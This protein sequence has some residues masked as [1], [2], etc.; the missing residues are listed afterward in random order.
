[1]N[2]KSP[3]R[4]HARPEGA[5]DLL[6]LYLFNMALSRYVYYW[7]TTVLRVERT[8]S[9]EPFGEFIDFGLQVNDT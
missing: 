1:M 2:Y 7:G 8:D 9:I 4:L 3:G 6:V 5:L